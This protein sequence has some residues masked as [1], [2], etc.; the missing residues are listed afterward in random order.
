MR[1]YSGMPFL[2]EY[3]STGRSLSVDTPL[4]TVTTRDRFAVI[5][6]THQDITLRFLTT[7]ELAA[8]MSFPRDYVFCGSETAAKKQIGNA[9][10]PL[11]AEAL[12]RAVLAA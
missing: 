7:G 1:K 12:Y 5:R 2:I 11:L 9:V 3:Y 4:H 10:P 6:R 8:A